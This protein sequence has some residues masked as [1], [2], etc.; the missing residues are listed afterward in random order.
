[1][2]QHTA[3]CLYLTSRPVMVELAGLKAF[4]GRFL[5]KNGVCW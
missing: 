4:Y 3:R 1:M 5:D 2:T